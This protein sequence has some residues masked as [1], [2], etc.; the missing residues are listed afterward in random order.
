MADIEPAT[1]LPWDADLSCCDGWDEY[2]EITKTR[3]LSLAWGT[4]HTLTGGR[5]GGCPVSIR[6]CLT[7]EP[8]TKCAG[9]GWMS[10]YIDHNGDWHNCARIDG[11]C[12]CSK[13]CEILLPGRAAAIT[14]VNVDG[15]DLDLALFRIDNGTRLVRQDG[16]CFPDCQDLTLPAGQAGTVTVEYV[17]GIP[18]TAAGLAAVGVLA[19]EFAKACGNGKCRLPTG[20]TNI[21]RQGVAMTLSS[22]MFDAGTGIREVDGYIYS[23]NPHGL[24][25]AP[26]VWTPDSPRAAHRVTT[27]VGETVVIP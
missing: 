17:P 14:N 25:T 27:W 7:T 22:G 8:C 13:M 12:S 18:V 9:G 19:C 3:A 16:Q 5:V 15:V 24:K 23:V 10:P 11:T 2:D 21:V 6:P 1:C 4:L 26:K 20:V